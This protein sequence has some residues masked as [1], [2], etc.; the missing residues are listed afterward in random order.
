MVMK[1][2][3]NIAIDTAR[4]KIPYKY[5]IFS[6]ANFV[7]ENLDNALISYTYRRGYVNRCLIIP[8][9]SRHSGGEDVDY[10]IVAKL[11]K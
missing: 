1:C 7:F 10:Y 11:K 8:E 6:K 5:I 3:L 2:E 4:N 9:G